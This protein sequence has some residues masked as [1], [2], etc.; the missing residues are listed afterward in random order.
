[1]TF[2]NGRDGRAGAR[3]RAATAALLIGLAGL[4]LAGCRPDEDGSRVAGWSMIDPAQRHP[5]GVSREPEHLAVTVPRGS[6]GLSPTQK[7]QVVEFAA[8]ARAADAGNTKMVVSAPAGSVNEVDSAEAVEQI[9]Y[10]LSQGG[11]AD[12]SVGLEAYQAGRERAPPIRVSFYRYVAHAPECGN[13]PANLA[14]EPQNI[15]YANFGCATQRNFANQVAN[16]ADLIE[17]RSETERD[18]DRRDTT[19]G[20]YVRGDP[21]N[22]PRSQGNDE[23]LDQ[24]GGN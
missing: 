4:G 12:S 14:R 8:R 16:P 13:W 10:L 23:K 11:I 24:L 2:D 1:M 22:A 3:R 19:Y 21:T 18:S 17:P 5:I 9:R 15:P 6:H 20:K 7:A